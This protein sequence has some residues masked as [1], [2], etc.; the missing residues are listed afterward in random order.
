MTCGC[1]P[2]YVCTDCLPERPDSWAA[3]VGW[4]ILLVP[5]AALL[6]CLLRELREPPL[7]VIPDYHAIACH[8]GALSQEYC[9]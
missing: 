8:E 5:C 6:W 7:F 3:T 2:D 9:R 4:A 1:G